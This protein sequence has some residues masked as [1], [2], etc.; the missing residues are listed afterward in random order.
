M[1]LMHNQHYYTCDV[2]GIKMTYKD[3]PYYEGMRAKHVMKINFM[4][5]S[6]KIMQTLHIPL[7]YGL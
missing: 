5:I 6:T 4:K 2:I 1:M 7:E 3:L